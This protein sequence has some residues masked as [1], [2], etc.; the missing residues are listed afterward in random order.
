MQAASMGPILGEIVQET[1]ASSVRTAVLDDLESLLALENQAFCSDRISRRQFRYLLTRAQART[2]VACDDGGA[3]V[4]YVMVLLRRGSH[5]ARIY[6]IAVDAACRHSGWGRRLV[7]AAERLASALGRTEMRLEVRTDN[8]SSQ[9]LF[10][11]LEYHPFAVQEDFYE[12]HA[13]AVRLYK[14]LIKK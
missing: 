10:A 5:R 2:L 1:H 9:A 8:A 14:L 7:L 4:G 13:A 11:A 12:D 3:I 6:S